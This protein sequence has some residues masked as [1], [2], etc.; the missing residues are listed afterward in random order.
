MA[1]DGGGVTSIGSLVDVPDDKTDDERTG[2]LRVLPGASVAP[3]ATDFLDGRSARLFISRGGTGGNGRR[4]HA[5]GG[6]REPRTGQRN[7]FSRSE[8]C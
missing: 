6:G 3:E 5:A 1:V 8:I 7:F 4:P 2:S